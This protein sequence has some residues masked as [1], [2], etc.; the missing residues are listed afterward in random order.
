[1][2]HLY[3]TRAERMGIVTL[4][5]VCSG[6]WLAPSF[7]PKRPSLAPEEWARYQAEFAAFQLQMA[8]D[9]PIVVPPFR[10]N[11]NTLSADS[12][13][14]LGLPEKTVRSIVNYREKGGRFYKTE[15]FEKIYTL[16]SADYQR[17]KNFVSI[18]KHTWTE[19]EALRPVTYAG[20]QSYPNWKN[21]TV[22]AVDINRSGLEEWMALPAI[23]EKR[24]RQILKFRDALGGFLSVEQVAETFQLPD[25]VYQ[26]IKPHLVMEFK[27]IKTLNINSASVEDLDKHP[28]ISTKQAN[29]I[30][31]YRSHHGPY[32][33]VDALADMVGLGG[34]NWLDKVRI[35]LSCE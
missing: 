29:L 14:M 21:K 2:N 22:Q 26:V 16:D 10:F 34:K 7:F 17:L 5:I 25:S 28:Y 15:D 4:V 3:F 20:G 13:R 32:K 8:K 23:G 27:G 19:P 11:P 9:T 35:Y 33:Q 30:V 6:I 1:M 18:P 12:L 24:A 31:N